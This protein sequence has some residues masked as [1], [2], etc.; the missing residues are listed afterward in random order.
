MIWEVTRWGKHV[1]LLGLSIYD[2]IHFWLF[3]RN[4]PKLIRQWSGE[5][6]GG[7]SDSD[8][9]L[10]FILCFIFQSVRYVCRYSLTCWMPNNVIHLQSLIA[11]S[12][13]ICWVEPCLDLLTLRKHNQHQKHRWSQTF[14]VN[15]IPF[16]DYQK[17]KIFSLIQKGE[18]ISFSTC[19]NV[20]L[21]LYAL[22]VINRH[23]QDCPTAA[24]LLGIRKLLK[25]IQRFL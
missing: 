3:S 21:Q 14:G 17:E 1:F 9:S 12:K 13:S 16:T 25:H 23:L 5:L 11:Y 20:F 10:L 7:N 2:L 18:N 24:F 6:G 4:H 19:A 22:K 15:L 8:S